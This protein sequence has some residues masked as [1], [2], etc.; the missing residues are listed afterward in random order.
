[1][2]ARP[3]HQPASVDGPAAYRGASPSAIRRHYDIGDDFYALWLD[4]TLTYSCGMWEGGE[5]TLRLAQLRKL[6]YLAWAV[7]A[8]GAERVLDVGC[9]WGGNLRRLVERH[10]VGH[11]VGLTLSDAQAKSIS[12][13]AEGN[14]EV[15]VENWIEH[16]PER[17]YD[18][19]VSIEAFEHFAD[20][21]M[22]RAARVEA[23]RVFFDRCRE[24]LPPGG[25]LALQ[26][27]VKG[28]NVR[29]D[30]QT[31][32]DLLFIADRIFPESELPWASEILQASERRF[33][34][35]SIR[36]DPGDYVRT[37]EQWLER[38]IVARPRGEEL[39]GE[40]VVDDYER[41]L[42]AA[43]AAFA[44]RHLGLMRIVFERP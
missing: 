42:R 41:Y 43:G 23:Y 21:G 28:N 30:R 32:R 24:W 3:E 13:W 7:D 18:A 16:L 9:G 14:C 33:D 4:S 20:F 15:R 8:V 11:A 5:D 38:L 44:N 25:R 40:Q 39:L 36:N 6:D 10:R 27:G 17:P 29:L 26:T 2:S 12:L 31:T 22:T 19:I 34:V 37:C 35:I 1:M